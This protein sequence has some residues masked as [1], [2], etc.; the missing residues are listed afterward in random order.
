ML[1]YERIGFSEG[2]SINKASA[3]K[4]CMLCH[5]LFF[6]EV[7]QKFEPHVCNEYDDV[8]MNTYESPDIAI[9]TVKGVD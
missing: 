3:S 4:E 6:K 7:G 9:L 2:I 5:Y 1:Q 8:L